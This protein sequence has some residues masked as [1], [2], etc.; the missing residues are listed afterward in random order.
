MP[1]VLITPHTA[2]HGPYLDER[3]FEIIARQLP[4]LP[5]RRA[6]PQRRR[7]GQLVLGRPLTEALPVP[8]GLNV[9]SRLVEHT[10]PYLDR[11]VAP[12]RLALVPG[13]RPVRGP[14]GGGGLD[15]LRLRPRALSGQAL[16]PRGAL[17]Q[18]PQPRASRQ[19]GRHGA[20]ALRRPGDPRHRRRLERGRVPGL[21]LAVPADARAHRAARRG[22]RADPADVARRARQLPGRALR[23]S[24]PP[25]ASRDPIPCR[26]SWW[27]AMA[28]S[29]CCAWWPATRTGG[30]TAS[31]T[32]TTYAHKQEVLKRHCREVGRDYDAI[33][34]V[35]RVGILI[36]ET[37]REVER[38][39]TAPRAGPCGH[40]PR[41]H[42]R[43]R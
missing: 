42:A 10:F 28:R 34:Q 37:E 1:G 2:G 30:T 19:D 43:P 39:K 41:R 8:V 9:W 6:A 11:T 18:L 5:R 14:P 32:S 23:R 35:V 25:T 7:Q 29:T 27:A 20:G 26:P 12:V 16:R 22:H 38:L 31:A 15:A 21:W 24:R 13:S 36:A 3:R 33:E 40:P 4:P 17:Q